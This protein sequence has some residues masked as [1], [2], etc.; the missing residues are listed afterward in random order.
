MVARLG[1]RCLEGAGTLTEV[2]LSEAAALP[3]GA[4]LNWCTCLL[5]DLCGFWA[6]EFSLA[7]ACGALLLSQRMLD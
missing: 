6:E 2:E 7:R 1:V 5:M 4:A 3:L